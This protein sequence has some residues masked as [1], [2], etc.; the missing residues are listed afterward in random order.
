MR[1]HRGKVPRGGK[2]LRRAGHSA[3]EGWSTREAAVECL[4][5]VLE[6][7][8]APKE[9]HSK[10]GSHLWVGGVSREAACCCAQPWSWALVAAG[11]TDKP[12]LLQ[13]C[14]EVLARNTSPASGLHPQGHG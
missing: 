3:L 10:W 11:A 1:W 6:M 2:D 12:L 8:S 14:T 7:L 4:A 9:N 13:G 5:T